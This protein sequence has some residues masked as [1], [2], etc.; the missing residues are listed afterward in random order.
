MTGTRTE[1]KLSWGES[2]GHLWRSGDNL[3][4]LALSSLW[5]LEVKL[6]LSGVAVEMAQ[7]Q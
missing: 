3:Q 5:V 7:S 4:G 6:R 2:M 1:L